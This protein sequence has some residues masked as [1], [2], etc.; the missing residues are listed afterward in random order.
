[1]KTILKLIFTLMPVVILA[2]NN[3]SFDIRAISEA[4]AIATVQTQEQLKEKAKDD[5]EAKLLNARITS[6]A[7]AEFGHQTVIMN[8]VRHKNTLFV[9]PTKIKESVFD[10]AAILSAKVKEHKSLILSGTVRDGISE[11]WWRFDGQHYKIFTNANFLYFSGFTEDIEHGETIYSV[12]L[13]VV[14][15]SSKLRIDTEGTSEWQPTHADFT[16][17]QLEYYVVQSSG[18]EGTDAKALEPL[19]RM[20]EYY[21][22]N[23]RRMKIS[24]ENAQKLRIA[25]QAYLEANPPKERDVIINSAPIDKSTRR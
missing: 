9:E 16:D 17:G 5:L 1:M 15:G 23:S 6:T 2:A 18:I 12:F 3:N 19:T 10:E 4:E 24:Y 11:L 13:I 22:K 8:R 14:K 21:Q 7:V 20:L 25:R